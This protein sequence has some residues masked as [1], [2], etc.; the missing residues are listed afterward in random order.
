MELLTRPEVIASGVAIFG[1]TA[2]ALLLTKPDIRTRLRR[3]ARQHAREWAGPGGAARVV[4]PEITFH[5]VNSEAGAGAEKTEAGARAGAEPEN[6]AVKFSDVTSGHPPVTFA[7]VAGL[8]EA[9]A[10]LADVRE[11]LSDP[12]RFRALGAE[13]PKGILLHGLPG[14]GKTLLARALAGETK[15]PFYFVSAASF[16]ERYVGVGAARVRELFDQALR[17]APSIVFIDELDAIGRQR[18]G[19]GAGDREFDNTLNQLLIELDGFRGASGVLVLG[20]TNRPELID[21]ALLR[22]GRFDRSIQIGR[23]DRSGREKILR[24]HASKRPVSPQVDWNEVADTT[25]GLSAAELANVVNEASLLAA[26]RRHHEIT[27]KDVEDANA[28]M[29]SGTRSTRLMGDEEK[30]VAAVHEA[31]H[32]LLSLLLR[33]MNPPARIS[34]MSGMDTRATSLWSSGTDREILTKRDLIAQLMLLLGGRAAELNVFAE[35]SNRAEDD[36]GHAATLARRMVERWA[37]TGR[38]ELA[39]GKREPVS[40]HFEGSAGGAEVR[41][42]LTRA[43]QAAR[44]ILRDNAGDLEAIAEA[45][46]HRETLTATELRGLA[47]RGTTAGAGGAAVRH[48]RVV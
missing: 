33:G 15:V 3:P 13:M 6:A 14:C 36:L 23:P 38:F 44:T 28:R 19:E 29:L 40:H 47:R 32:A 22:P 42:L 2:L 9:I 16:V 18:T 45:L 7:D 17:T 5:V 30:R 1:I 46:V 20:A 12:D 48:L 27:K 39:G 43:E 10:E 35:P 26:R 25:A 21:P 11:Y 37:M 41:D 4:K 31:G 34:L 8:E 24:L